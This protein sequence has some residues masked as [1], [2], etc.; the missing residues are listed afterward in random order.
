MSL[1]KLALVVEVKALE[2]ATEDVV[3]RING[4]LIGA[5]APLGLR[6]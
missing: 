2:M 5:V 4:Y 3:P 6:R 1:K